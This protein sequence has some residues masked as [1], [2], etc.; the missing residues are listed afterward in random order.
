MKRGLLI[1]LAL[2]GASLVVWLVRGREAAVEIPFARARRATLV[3]LI[4]T[5]GRAEPGERRAIHAESAGLVARV[6]V[7]QGEAVRA[8]AALVT[9]SDPEAAAGMETARARLDSARAALA[10]LEQG[11]P[12]RD[13]AAIDAAIAALEVE[14]AAA[15]R[16]AAGLERLVGQKAATVVELDAARDR[17]KRAETDLAAQR[18]RRGLLVESAETAAARAR[19]REAEAALELAAGRAGARVLRA[20][21]AGVV[22]EVAVRAG[23]WMAPGALAARV[24]RLDPL[25]ARVYVDEP[26]LG[27]LREGQEVVLTWDALPGRRW[28]G[29]IERLPT[30]VA[31]LGS[32]QVGEAL[33]SVPNP[34]GALPP[35]ANINA[36]IRAEQVEG[37]LSVPKEALQRNGAATGVYVVEQGRLAWRPVR[38][39]VSTVT[40]AQVLEGLGEGEAVALPG[41]AALTPGLAV[42][43]V[44]R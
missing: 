13:A 32:R 6:D 40:E 33:V 34:D 11:G 3:S 28:S 22:Y 8:G 41:G 5:N 30:Q 17:V 10:L 43:P 31:A 36:E 1:L 14:R 27:R 19:V 18:R 29:R 23:D 24:G 2:A 37:A 9:L 39:G 35:G 16:E 21:G 25:E 42:K 26:D 44:Y 20:P 38:V 15:A 7:R 12:A 4:T